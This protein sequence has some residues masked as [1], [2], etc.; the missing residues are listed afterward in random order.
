[1]SRK[2]RDYEKELG[3]IMDSLAESVADISDEE[4][5]ADAHQEGRNPEVAASQIRNMLLGAVDRFERTSASPKAA[6]TALAQ[7][8]VAKAAQLGMNV[9]R[10]ADITELSPV[11]ITMFDRRL[12]RLGSIPA[13]VLARI[14]SALNS[15]AEEVAAYFTGQ[16]LFPAGEFKADRA[17]TLPDQQEFFEAV[18]RDPSIGEERKRKLLD[19]EAAG[20]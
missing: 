8:L 10:L 1:M 5:V 12:I 17:P 20:R 9:M 4:L 2:A 11:L 6:T 3:A 14:S 18:R 16:A 15:S 13:Q 19:L 7:G